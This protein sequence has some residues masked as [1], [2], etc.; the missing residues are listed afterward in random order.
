MCLEALSII[1]LT[2]EQIE[3]VDKFLF[4]LQ[5]HWKLYR[6]LGALEFDLKLHAA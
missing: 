4:V 3:M 1:W 6:E 2:Q 5:Q